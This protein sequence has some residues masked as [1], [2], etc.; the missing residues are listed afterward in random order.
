ME[1]V[2]TEEG[3]VRDLKIFVRIY[4]YQ[5]SSVISLEEGPRAEIARNADEL[6]NL[7]KKI[8][9]RLQRI[10]TEEQV[11]KVKPKTAQAERKVERAVKRVASVFIKEVGTEFTLKST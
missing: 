11:E 8:Y 1:L 6:L 4:L 5:L 3:Y 9:R 7:H 10:I 2:S